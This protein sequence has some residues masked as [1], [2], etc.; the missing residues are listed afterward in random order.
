MVKKFLATNPYFHFR[1]H[2]LPLNVL[3]VTPVTLPKQCHSEGRLGLK[4]QASYSSFA[5]R[6]ESIA[7]CLGAMILSTTPSQLFQVRF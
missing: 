3:T 5:T 6:L 7:L 4:W 1:L 2:R